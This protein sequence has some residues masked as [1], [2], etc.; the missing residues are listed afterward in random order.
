MPLVELDIEEHFVIEIMR[1]YRFLYEY[2]YNINSVLVHFREFG[3]TYRSDK[4]KREIQL[5][6]WLPEYFFCAIVNNKYIWKKIM[7]RDLYKYFHCEYLDVKIN[8]N[9]YS[10]FIKNNAEF[11]K[12]NLLPLLKGEEWIRSLSSRY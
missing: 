4:A 8:P 1:N 6:W 2:D 9:N 11:A 12:S 5:Y 3:V 10:E 7:I